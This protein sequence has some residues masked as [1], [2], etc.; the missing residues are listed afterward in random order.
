[1]QHLGETA[2]LGTAG[3]WAIGSLLFTEAARRAGVFALNIFRITLALFFLSFLL[4]LTGDIHH[5]PAWNSPGV[6]WLVVSG[7]VGL[8]IGDMGYFGALVRLGPRMATVFSALSAPLT[9][10]L[11]IPLLGEHM[12][13]VAVLGMALTL[14]GVSWVVLERPV[15]EPPRGHR[16][17]GVFLGILYAFCQALGL[18]LAKRGMAYGIEPLMATAFRMAAAAAG[19]WIVALLAGRL[20]APRLIWSNPVAR[21]SAIGATL[22]GPTFGV[23]LSLVAARHT[24][25]GIAATLMS[26]VPVLILPLVVFV[27]RETVS[28]RAAFGAVLAVVGVGL[29]YL[30]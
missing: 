12:G 4:F 8:S 15:T 10:L 25:A 2:A 13:I 20:A 22:V 14:V 3:L 17:Q 21:Y 29:I 9:A 23:L 27:R 7:L 18:V 26:T 30:R 16:I 1:M 6:R 5:L 28:P 19:I 11:A 24:S